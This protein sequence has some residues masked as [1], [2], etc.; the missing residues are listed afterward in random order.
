MVLADVL[1]YLSPLSDDRL[2]AVA[3]D[4]GRLLV[5][6]GLL[7]LVNHHFYFEVIPGAKMT[8]P[9]QEAFRWS[10]AFTLLEEQW[11]PFYLSSLLEKRTCPPPLVDAI[12]TERRAAVLR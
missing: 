9:I 3:E 2:K 7:L 6:G 12:P 11:R 8:R 10:P 4:V 5:P 1:Y